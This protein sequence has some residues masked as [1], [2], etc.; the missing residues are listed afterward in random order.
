[1]ATATGVLPE[2]TQVILMESESLYEV[3]DGQQRE[4]PPTSTLA[5]LVASV[6]A[7]YLGPFAVQ[8]QLGIV[9]V[10]VLFRWAASRPQ[11]R[12]AIAFVAYDRWPNPTLRGEESAAWQ[13][14]PNLAVEVI[15]PTDLAEELLDKIDEYFNAGV[16]LVWV[17]FPRHRRIYVFDSPTQVRILTDADEL[18]GGEIVPGFRLSIATLFAPL[19]RPQ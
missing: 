5:G 7:Q 14:V 8:H 12:P 15:S 3:I 10:E 9:A 19:D 17:V 13:V 1:M 4:I 2:P 6:L 11:R 16:E 18:N